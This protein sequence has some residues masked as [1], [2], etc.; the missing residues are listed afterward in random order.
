MLFTEEKAL[1]VLHKL[2]D[3]HGATTQQIQ[4]VNPETSELDGTTVEMA[5]VAVAYNDILTTH[6]SFFADAEPEP[7]VAKKKKRRGA[8]NPNIGWPTGVKRAE[9]MEWKAAQQ[10]AGV[11]EG[12][13]PQAY[14]AQ[15][16]GL[17]VEQVQAE[18]TAADSDDDAIEIDDEP[19]VKPAKVEKAQTDPKSQSKAAAKK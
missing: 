13:N 12:L 5:N 4:A 3:K 2:I 10:A 1:E 16:D 9:Y 15:R 8:A 6:F 18:S 19:E 11:T 7:V 17:T 14:K